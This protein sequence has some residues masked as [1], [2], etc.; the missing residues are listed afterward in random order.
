M[1]NA[2]PVTAILV[3]YNQAT[4]V[5]RAVQSILAQD[6]PNLEIILSDDASTDTTFEVLERLASEYNGPHRVRIRRNPKNRMTEHVPIVCEEASHD[7]IVQF[8]GDDTSVPHR[9]SRIVDTMATTRA[10]LVGSNALQIDETGKPYGTYLPRTHRWAWRGL[11]QSIRGGWTG[12]FLGATLGFQRRLYAS[13][14]PTL[15]NRKMFGGN[16]VI[17]PFRASLIGPLSW[18]PDPLVVYRR[19]RG[20]ASHQMADWSSGRAAFD[21]TVCAH[22][23]MITAQKVRDIEALRAAKAVSEDQLEIASAAVRAHLYDQVLAWSERRAEVMDDGRRPA[24]LPLEVYNKW[25][26]GTP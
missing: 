4:M 10:V 25:R 7:I 20:Q 22:H 3:A 6:Y 11:S 9:V 18:I 24:W 26:A 15:S 21:E 23:M 19:H 8:H 2:T 16:D 13:P 5:H 12:E 1:P 17:L 14:F